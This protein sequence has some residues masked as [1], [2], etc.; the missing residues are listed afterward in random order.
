MIQPHRFRRVPWLLT[1][2]LATGIAALA[3]GTPVLGDGPRGVVMALFDPLC[4]QRPER[5]FSS[6][7]VHFA[8]CH[9]C[10][11]VAAGLA[12]GALLAP[13]L[14]RFVRSADGRA[15]PAL[16][17]AALPMLADWAL[18]AAGVWLNTPFTRAATGVVFG[19]VAGAVLVG[20]VAGVRAGVASS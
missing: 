5:S 11:G 8:L 3:A 1:T 9:R 7:G 19:F 2:A 12:L 13:L 16:A 4:H 6:A 20:S 17:L 18:D 14:G 10:F 15:L